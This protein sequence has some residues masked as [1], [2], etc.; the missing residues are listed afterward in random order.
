MTTWLQNG[1]IYTA[2]NAVNAGLL[3]AIQIYHD[4]AD[5]NFHNW[6]GIKGI[7]WQISAAILA[8][9]ALVWGPKILKWSTTNGQPP[10]APPGGTIQ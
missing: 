5:N 6:H 7:I 3:A 9:E 10:L 8:R 4:P 2:K 1:L